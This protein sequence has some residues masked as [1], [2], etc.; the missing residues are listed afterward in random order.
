MP[1][2]DYRVI[3]QAVRRREQ[4][5]FL[6]SELPR[7]CCPIILGYKADGSEA[8]FVYQFAGAASGKAA[9]PE[10]RCLSVAKIGGLQVRAGSWYEG[11]SHTQAQT[12]VRF[13]DVDVNIPETLRRK[14]P[15]PFGS[16]DLQLPRRG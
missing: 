14:A 11:T 5:M 2:N 6:Y 13:V 1:S 16:P 8:V 4:I 3:W 7:A 12:C 15:L 10:W 9:L